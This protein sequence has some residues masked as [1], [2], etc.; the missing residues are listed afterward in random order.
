MVWSSTM[1]VSA[2]M[3]A[4]AIGTTDAGPLSTGICYA[5]W[6]H[7]TVDSDVV[8]K[9]MAQTAQYFSSI[10]TFQAQFSSV[11]A[12]G[13]AAAA[14]LKIAVGV[15]LT[16]PALIDSEIQAV[17]DGYGAN[18]DA[19]EAVYVGNENLQNKDFGT[20]SAD[21]LIG[22]IT[23]VKA[24]VGSTPVGSVQRINE[25]LSAE[26]APALSSASDLIGVNIYPFFTA[27]PQTAVEKL[28]TQW[29]QMTAKYDAGKVRMTET[30][31]PSEGENNGQNA[32]SL[33]GLQQ[34]MDD[35][36]TWSKSVGQSYW[37]MMFDT[38][39]SYTGAEYEKHFGIF[40]SDGSA[41]GV[42]IPSGD[43]ASKTNSTASQ[44]QQQPTD[45]PTV[46]KD[47]ATTAPSATTATPTYSFGDKTAADALSVVRSAA[48]TAPVD[49]FS[50]ETP[51]IWIHLRFTAPSTA[52]SLVFTTG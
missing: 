7:T 33:E 37:F 9:D 10:R 47:T 21:Q 8:G 13:A 39:V 49:F 25:W 12:I 28:E 23:R 20:F 5:P 40:T 26:G 45:T 29:E 11:N 6:H 52:T 34:Y 42:V 43:G 46:T 41:K 51:C 27:G 22:Y 18:P 24:C 35:Y 15:Q 38:T 16:D 4:L 50:P 44:Q 36:V 2:L 32:P 48:P 14:G 19:V 31:W 17:C 1:R 30:G 3:A